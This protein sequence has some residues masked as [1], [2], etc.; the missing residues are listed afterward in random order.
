MK[1]QSYVLIGFVSQLCLAA[2]FIYRQKNFERSS[3]LLV[4]ALSL[5]G[6]G[7]FTYCL[8]ILY[9]RDKR[10]KKLITNGVFKFTRHPMYTGVFIADCFFW[11]SENFNQYFWFSGGLFLLSLV[12]AGYFQE[13]ETL[14][15][16]GKPAEDYYAKTPRLFIFYP[17]RKFVLI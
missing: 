8:Y 7:V 14:A 5:L 3:S 2:F 10:G 9:L 1:K 6:M 13:R 4:Q 17:F 16:F 11:H 15:R 12:L